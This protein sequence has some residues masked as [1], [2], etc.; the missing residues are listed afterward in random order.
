MAFK[1][2][3][4]VKN[5]EREFETFLEAQKVFEDQDADAQRRLD[6]IE[7][8]LEHQ[9]IYYVLGMLSKLFKDNRVED[10]KYIDAAFIAFKTKPKRE[11][12]FE[13]LFKMLKSDNAYLRNAVISFLQ[14]YGEGAKP[15]IEK[16]MHDSNRDIRIF[17][18][19][20]LGDVRYEDSI[21][22]LRHFIVQESDVNALMTAVD[23]IGEIGTQ[24]DIELLEA[25]KRA[26]C[27]DAYVEFGVQMAIDRIKG[28]L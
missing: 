2:T 24:S 25:I 4:I 17:A 23:Y 11:K 6:A 18:I 1:K 8:I 16:L 22:M 21:D 28:N 3:E 12:D 13:E 9:E 5:K 7:Y 26:H 27:E 14:E 20:I 15:F 19:N 10:N